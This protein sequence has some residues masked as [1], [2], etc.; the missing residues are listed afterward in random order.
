MITM[1]LSIF[2]L[3]RQAGVEYTHE[4]R[5]SHYAAGYSSRFS[6]SFFIGGLIY[7]QITSEPTVPDQVF[8]TLDLNQPIQENETSPLEKGLTLQDLWLHIHRAEIDPRIKGLLLTIDNLQGSSVVFE[9]IGDMVT[10]FRKSTGKPVVAQLINGGLRDLYLASFADKVYALKG[11]DLFITGLAGQATFIRKTLDLLGVESEFFHIGVYKTASNMYTHTEMTPEHRESFEVFFGD[12]HQS[13]AKGIAQNR[14][15][16]TER[17]ESLI[18]ESPF[19]NQAFLEAKL[20]DGIGYPDEVLELAGFADAKTFSF[21]TYMK[22]SSPKA[23]EGKDSIAVVFAEGEIHQGPSGKGGLF[24]DKIM[25]SDTLVAQLRKLRKNTRIK[26]VLL[27]INSPGG[28]ALAS[29]LIAREAE[30]L[31]KEK[32]LVVSMGGMAA[33]GGYWMS[34]P[35]SY[36]FSNRLT[37]TGSIGVLFGKFNLKGLYDKVGVTKETVKTSTYADIFSDYRSFTPKE[38]EKITGMM[39]QLYDDF[40]NKVSGSRKMSYDEVHAVAQG[41]IWSGTRAR[42]IKLV[43]EMGGLWPALEKTA[44]LAELKAGSYSVQCYPAKKD[45]FDMILEM[46]SSN[47]ASASSGIKEVQARFETYKRSFFPAL[48]MVYNLGIH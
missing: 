1:P 4:T 47:G 17:V 16:E 34:M 10:R 6:V 36:I 19:S 13:L 39:Q 11:S 23:F 45:V 18:Q 30:L 3:S 21:E 46:V 33:S 26:G 41:R 2:R 44:E 42:D 40:V 25:G 14:A 28:S 5:S 8:L 27:R 24:G 29:D 48:R 38:R 7:F 43:D 31:A 9:E 12:L 20:I 35:A 37:V 15:I 32:P 22:T